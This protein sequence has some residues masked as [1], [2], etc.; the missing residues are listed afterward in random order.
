MIK[1]KRVKITFHTLVKRLYKKKNDK[2]SQEYPF[3][4]AENIL[5]YISQR[6]KI[7]RFY[8]IKGGKFCF[9]ESPIKKD[10][11]EEDDFLLSGFIKS[12]R[13]EFRPNLIDK[14]TGDEREN[15]KTINEGDI[16]KTHF[17][18]KFSKSQ[19][20]VYLFFEYNSSGITITNFVNY[21]IFATKK[22]ICKNNQKINFK[23]IHCEVAR[24]NF[25]EELKNLSRAAQTEVYFDK[26]LLGSDALNF[27]NRTIALKKDIVLLAKASKKENI[28]E[29]GV[30]IWN[31]MNQK[32]SP[33]SKLRIKG[34]DSNENPIL[35]DTSFMVKNDFVDIDVDQDTGELNTIQ[36]IVGI[37][38]IASSV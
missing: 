22:Y 23:V 30:D 3:W 19:N 6:P 16:E 13:N 14:K 33:I 2:E 7:E 26:R 31:K 38:N 32:N 8:N 15:P 10:I 35:L 34:I 36:L 12:A 9:L 18:L 11:I 25:F 27:S 37:K 24:D 29:F 4:E 21:L 5:M 28:I 20:E 17:V 1:T